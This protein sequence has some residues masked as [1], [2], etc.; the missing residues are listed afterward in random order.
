MYFDWGHLLG[1][2]G[3]NLSQNLTIFL[4]KYNA[5]TLWLETNMKNYFPL[6]YVKNKKKRLKY[7]LS[8]S[9]CHRKK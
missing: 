5:D 8:P 2:G 4:P 1:I 6:N 7:K 9:N 3:E